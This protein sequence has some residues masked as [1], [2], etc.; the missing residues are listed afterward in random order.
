MSVYLDYNASSPIDPRVLE[1]MTDVY[2][3]HYGNPDS[4]THT[5]GIAARELVEEARGRI[6]HLLG[7]ESHEVYFTSGSTESNNMAILGMAQWGVEQGKT[8]I[9]TS[10]MEHKSI[11][12]PIRCLEG[13]GFTA[14]YIAPGADGRIS[15]QEL[16]RRV[17]DRTLMVCLMHANN[18]TGV[19]Q[20]VDEIG[21]VLRER[22]VYFLLDG[23]QTCGK[24]VPE[25]RGLVYDFLSVSAHKFHGPQGVGILIVRRRNYKQPPIRPIMMGGGQENG[26]RPGTIPV[27]LTAGMG[28]AAELAER[29][30]KV[31]RD[32]TAETKRTF[33]TALKKSGVTFR[34]NGD[35]E[36]CMPN[37]LNISFPGVDSEA[38][39]LALKGTCS[40]SNGSACTAKD[41]SHSHVLNTMGLSEEE[42]ESAVRISWDVEEVSQGLQALIEMVRM[43]Q[44]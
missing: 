29:E 44:G 3:N 40:F 17:T 34:I 32:R 7:V 42:M 15:A 9:I 28:C 24:L 41:Y 35:Q 20:P 25:L 18:E 10:T 1:V 12:E 39:M 6:A 30:Y 37:T 22:D 8:H 4:R 11:L 2:R 14:D 31:W 27:A 19:V 16:L 21:A 26:L 43:L 38:L 33:L 13:R 5:E 23:A 36:H